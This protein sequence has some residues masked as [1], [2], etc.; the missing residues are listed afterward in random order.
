MR[1]DIAHAI[2]EATDVR[3]VLGALARGTLAPRDLDGLPVGWERGPSSMAT[4]RALGEL[5]GLILAGLLASWE[6]WGRARVD[7]VVRFLAPEAGV[8]VDGRRR[9]YLADLVARAPARGE[10]L[11]AVGR[12]G[13]TAARLEESRVAGR[14]VVRA[15]A[16]TL[17]GVEDN[18]QRE[19][20]AAGLA[21]A[22]ARDAS[23]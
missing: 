14:E 17:A 6:T 16:R 9:G 5:H 21:V 23:R 10:A 8:M 1:G 4:G 18:A 12:V 3:R 7:A 20:L 11:R 19:V 2:V 13:W 15:V 22:L